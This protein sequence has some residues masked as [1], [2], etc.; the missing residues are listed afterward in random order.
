MDTNRFN[1]LFRRA[2]AFFLDSLLIFGV[3]VAV[4]QWLIF[5]P[6]RR[7]ILTSEDWFRSGWNT[8][9]Y[10]LLTISLPVWLY[11]ILFE[12]SAWQATPSKRLFRL[13]TT[14]LSGKTRIGLKQVILRTLLK[15]LP[16]EIAHLTNNLPVPMWYDLNPGFRLGFAIVPILIILYIILVLVTPKHQGLHDLVANTVVRID[17]R[18]G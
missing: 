4:A 16:W 11:F 15:L 6:L 2:A 17:G 9:A 12:L 8:E 18:R 14:D 5:V 3:V 10:T 1:L 7:Q 13:R